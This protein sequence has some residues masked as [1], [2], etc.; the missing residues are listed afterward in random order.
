MPE[1]RGI[2]NPG[3][4]RFAHAHW[5]RLCG[6]FGFITRSLIRSGSLV[7]Y[8]F[9]AKCQLDTPIIYKVVIESSYGIILI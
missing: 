4:V 6:S 9:F 2:L 1:N 8:S 5:N 7:V 3:S